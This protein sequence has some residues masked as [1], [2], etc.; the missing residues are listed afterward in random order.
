MS[1][2]KIRAMI[3]FCGE[4]NLTGTRKGDEGASISD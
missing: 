4:R 3:R 1:P 2:Q